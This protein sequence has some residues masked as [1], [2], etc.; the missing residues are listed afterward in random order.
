VL[1]R[2]YLTEAAFR[3]MGVD[4]GGGD[5][6]VAEKLL[7]RAQVS[8]AFEEVGGEGVAKDVGTD[9]FTVDAGKDR[10]FLEQL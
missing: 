1:G 2:D 8:A 6:G 7:H 9:A 5:V 3:D 10:R 4:L